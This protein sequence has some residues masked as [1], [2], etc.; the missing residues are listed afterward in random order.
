MKKTLLSVS[1]LVASFAMGSVANA[2]C[3]DADMVIYNTKIYTVNKEQPTA[4]AVVVKDSKIV[5]VGSN[6]SIQDYMCGSAA[7]YNLEGRYVYPGFTD[8]HVHVKN[9]GRREYLLN[10]QGIDDLQTMIDKTREYAAGVKDGEWLQGGRWIEKKWPEKRFPT[11]HDIDPF[12]K[13]KP[14]YLKRAAGHS[15]LTNSKGLEIAGITRDTPDPDGGHIVKD[16]NGEPTGMLVDNAMELI[17]RHIPEASY[18][19]EKAYIQAGIDFMTRMGWTQI[20]EAG[21][22]YADVEIIK[23]IHSEGKLGTRMYYAMWM[24]EEGN[25]LIREGR[26]I[27]EDNM[28]DI[29]GIKYMADGALGS[30]GAAMLEPYSDDPH[31]HGLVLMKRETSVPV[32]IEALKKGIQIETHA[33]GD[34]ANRDVLNFY[35]E[36]FN[37]VPPEERH[38][39]DP[40]WRI[41]HAQIIH[42]DDQQRFI[43]LGV[44]M[45][46][47]PS[48][49]KG[50]LYFAIDRIQ[51]NR[52]NY[53]YLWK[54]MMEKGAVVA[55]GTDAPVEIGDPRIEFYSL[56]Q[57]TDWN[58]YHNK[59]WHVEERITREAALE[60]LTLTNAYAAR[61]EDIRGSIEVGK[62]A[63]FTI[64]DRDIMEGAPIKVMDATNVMTVVGGKITYQK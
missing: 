45:A 15:I 4:E 13:N 56:I 12:T 30:R 31:N 59:D 51:S 44:I 5:H 2:A 29:A 37:A 53:A 49:V 34:A 22:S 47:E 41:E 64:F 57:R 10:L 1:A 42:P 33:I 18:E 55:A 61:Q 39:A 8:A 43:D 7:L 62:L 38:F 17:E 14:V 23:D 9:I 20:Q 16:E 50:D 26:Q 40:R 28:I 25:R 36:A 3:K 48:T 27:S 32:L 24:G 58:G 63:D 6:A 46:I 54:S 11:R 60:M 19:Q 52:L 21:G 35:E